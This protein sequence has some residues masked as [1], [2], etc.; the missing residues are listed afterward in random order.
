M[1]LD[2][3]D[4]DLKLNTFRMLKEIMETFNILLRKVGRQHLKE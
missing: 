2:L 1:I 3:A 4:Q